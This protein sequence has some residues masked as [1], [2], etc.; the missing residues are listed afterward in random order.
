MFALFLVLNDTDYL[1]EILARFVDVG[2]QG[3]T[4]VDSQ[5]MASALVS[6]RGRDYP[7]S[8]PLKLC[9]KEPGLIT[10]PFLLSL[11]VRNL[12]KGPWRRCGMCCPARSTPV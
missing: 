8:A 1:D 4:I 5:G 6:S 11:R 2:V 7:S 10:K 12:W 9:W 3:A